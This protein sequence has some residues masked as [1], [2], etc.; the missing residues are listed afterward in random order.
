MNGYLAFMK[1]EWIEQIRTYKLFI[2]LVL[3]FIFGML[4]PLTAKLMPELL[5]QF[6]IEG[7]TIILP[8][9]SALDSYT[10]FFKNCSQM[11][12]LILVIVFSSSLTHELMKGT[13]TN[14]VTKGLSRSAIIVSK[15]I[16]SLFIWTISLL[17]S[18]IT[19][20]FYTVYLFPEDKIYHLLSSVGCLWLFGIFLL[21]LSLLA[22]TLIKSQYGNLMMV[23]LSIGSLFILNLFPKF[24]EYNPLVLISKNVSMLSQDYD[25]SSLLIPIGVTSGLIITCLMTAIYLFK[26]KSL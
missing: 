9:P 5:S 7:M 8:E 26:T 11:G 18:F 10:Q 23:A 25:L 4:S 16:V 14:L 1:K 3:F 21:S 6:P 24:Q 12:L 2:L 15:F 19:T 13:L 22:Q 17:L 20:W